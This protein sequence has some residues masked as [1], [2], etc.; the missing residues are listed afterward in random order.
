MFRSFL[1]L[2]E[3]GPS[4]ALVLHPSAGQRAPVVLRLRRLGYEVLEASND[5]QARALLSEHHVEQV[6][7]LSASARRLAA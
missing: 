4:K 7:D 1:R 6:V 5:E 3:P 2:V